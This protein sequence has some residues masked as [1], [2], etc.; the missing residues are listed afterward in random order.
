MAMGL[1]FKDA[2]TMDPI[3][4]IWSYTEP[5]GF[6]MDFFSPES[7]SL[8]WADY[9]SPEATNIWESV[10]QNNKKNGGIIDQIDEFMGYLD[11]EQSKNQYLNQASPYTSGSPSTMSG[12]SS[13]W[14]Q[15][16]QGNVGA[17][18]TNQGPTLG[19]SVVHAANAANKAN[20]MGQMAGQQMG[21]GIKDIAK[22]G[23]NFASNKLTNMALSAI[24]GV[25][26][27]LAIANNVY[28]GGAMGLV[29]DGIGVVQ[30]VGGEIA[31][32]AGDAIE[33]VGNVVGDVWD[34]TVGRVIDWICDERLKIDIA[35]LES[36]E[37][38]Y[39]LAQMAFFVKGL[40]ECS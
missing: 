7:T 29:K 5:S 40:R 8:N 33:G 10:N 30:D 23:A 24:P 39:E 12:G 1:D 35:P 18:G 26:P 9:Y 34:N 20:S 38:N 11:N 4:D 6:N 22:I 3:Y 16:I 25:G 37:V 13:T 14:W 28:P 36:T 2:F 32:F 17:W 31:G 19:A 27:A 21:F 15:P